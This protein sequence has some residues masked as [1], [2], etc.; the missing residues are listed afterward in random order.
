M[1][2]TT[3]NLNEEFLEAVILG[4]KVV[5]WARYTSVDN[6]AVLDEVHCDCVYC[7]GMRNAV[8]VGKVVEHS[9]FGGAPV[10]LTLF[11]KDQREYEEAFKGGEPPAN[12]RTLAYATSTGGSTGVVELPLTSSFPDIR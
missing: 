9:A 4:G 3:V 10:T 11:Y 6:G 2:N 1:G 8:R 7:G 5:R 12:A